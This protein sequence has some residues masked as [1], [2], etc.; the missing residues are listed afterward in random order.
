MYTH[1][2]WF[3]TYDPVN[4]NIVHMGNNAQCNVG[5]IDIIKNQDP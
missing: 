1:Q 3:S 4:I 5:G 2:D